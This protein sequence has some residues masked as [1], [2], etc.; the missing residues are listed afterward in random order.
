MF[1]PALQLFQLCWCDPISIS[2]RAVSC[3]F[4]TAAPAT[5]GINYH[6]AAP[7]AA[8]MPLYS[9]QY[10]SLT[11]CLSDVAVACSAIR[12]VPGLSCT[13]PSYTV[14]LLKLTRLYMILLWG[15]VITCCGAV[16]QYP[17][18]GG[19]GRGLGTHGRAQAAGLRRN[20][21][22]DTNKRTR[23]PLLL[24]PAMQGE[25]QNVY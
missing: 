1:V 4:G 14:E 7:P 13:V 16:W 25:P 5:T 8:Y 10:L 24:V 12:A 21:K 17:S 6:A 23:H 20:T 2:S 3:H 18:C 15:C 22:P 19:L 9:R 11:G